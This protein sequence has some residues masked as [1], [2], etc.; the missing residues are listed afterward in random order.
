MASVAPLGPGPQLFIKMNY[1]VKAYGGRQFVGYA[2]VSGDIFLSGQESFSSNTSGNTLTIDF[3]DRDVSISQQLDC[4]ISGNSLH[5]DGQDISIGTISTTEE[6]EEFGI[7][8]AI[9]LSGSAN[10]Y[11]QFA[12]SVSA[13]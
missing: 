10:H 12:Y 5:L 11:M 2:S 13:G 9:F 7:R 6:K 3:G 8:N 1:S 4:D